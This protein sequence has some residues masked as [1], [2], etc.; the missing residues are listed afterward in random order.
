MLIFPLNLSI[1]TTYCGTLSLFVTRGY[2]LDGYL[3]GSKSCPPEVVDS[4]GPNS[5][6]LVINS[7]PFDSW[8]QEQLLSGWI[9]LSITEGVLNQLIR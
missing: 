5:E 8:Q 6:M 1:L 7:A 3:A 9:L 2:N 4:H